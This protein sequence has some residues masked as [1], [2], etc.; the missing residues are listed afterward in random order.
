MFVEQPG[1][2][3]AP[4][5]RGRVAV[6]DVAFAGGENFEKSTLPFLDALGDRLAIW[7]DHH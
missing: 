4:P 6:V 5:A 2:L 7:I 1:K 3:P